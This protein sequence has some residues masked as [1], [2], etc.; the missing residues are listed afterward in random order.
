MFERRKNWDLGQKWKRVVSA[1]AKREAWVMSK[2]WQESRSDDL[3]RNKQ[4]LSCKSVTQA[5]L[6]LLEE[7]CGRDWKGRWNG[8][9]LSFGH[10]LALH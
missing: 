2:N 5:A 10:G 3:T 8:E 6:G 1:A 9:H 4:E 7:H